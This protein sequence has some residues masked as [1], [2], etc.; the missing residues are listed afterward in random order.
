M[1]VCFDDVKRYHAAT[2]P[3][4][5]AMENAAIHVDHAPRAFAASAGVHRIRFAV[6]CDGR[7]AAKRR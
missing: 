6:K 2:G 4:E 1:E 7:R 3:R 5:R